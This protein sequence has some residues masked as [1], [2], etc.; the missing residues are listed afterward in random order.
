M[1]ESGKILMSARLDLYT[2]GIFV[3]SLPVP[4]RLLVTLGV[5]ERFH[6]EA[7]QILRGVNKYPLFYVEL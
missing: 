4:L 1:A 5:V 2:L 7:Q 6:C 3:R